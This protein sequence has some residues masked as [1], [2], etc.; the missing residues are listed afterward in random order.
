QGQTSSTVPHPN[1]TV[2]PN[3]NRLTAPSGYNYGYDAAG[4]QTNDTD[5]GE[6]ART[7]DAKSRLKQ[8]WANNQWQTYNYDGDGQRIKRV[9]NGTETWQVYGI[10]AELI[11]E[12]AVNGAPSSPQKEYGY[13][14]G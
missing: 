7:Y 1:Y 11:A 3:T 13:R 4:N 14:N 12:Y 6:G 9:V 2:D 8:A 5:T 10:G